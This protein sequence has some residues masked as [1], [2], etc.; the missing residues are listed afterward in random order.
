VGALGYFLLTGTPPFVGE[1]VAEVCAHHLHTAPL[2]PSRRAGR[3]VPAEL[4]AV[5]LQCLAKSPE[6][7]PESA[8]ALRAALLEVA[9]TW[10]EED[11]G[12]WWAEH[13][14]AES[15]RAP[16]AL[17]SASRIEHAP[18]LLHALAG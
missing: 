2:A 15:C 1:S 18:T 11:A 10:T 8:A 3:R 7:R 13:R 17:P 12:C 16:R 5:L 9:A 6:D 14:K 4:E